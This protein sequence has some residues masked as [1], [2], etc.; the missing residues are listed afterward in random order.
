MGDRS[1]SARRESTKVTRISLG[2]IS[3]SQTTSLIIDLHLGC[4]C[5]LQ[6]RVSLKNT[7]LARGIDLDIGI[8]S[9]LS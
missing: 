8:L 9:L 6:N 5:V 1:V 3:D 4:F 7:I 2:S